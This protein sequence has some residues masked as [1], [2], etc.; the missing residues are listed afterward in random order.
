MWRIMVTE[1]PLQNKMSDFQSVLF[2]KVF[3]FEQLQK[4]LMEFSGEV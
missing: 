2:V 3:L 4:N 1:S